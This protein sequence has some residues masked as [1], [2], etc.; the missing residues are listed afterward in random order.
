MGIPGSGVVGDCHGGPGGD[1]SP[2]TY[3]GHWALLALPW[4]RAGA[5]HCWNRSLENMWL[6]RLR[7]C[8]PFAIPGVQSQPYSEYACPAVMHRKA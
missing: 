2:R 5:A 3:V 4:T 7:L 1:W 6:S 8:S